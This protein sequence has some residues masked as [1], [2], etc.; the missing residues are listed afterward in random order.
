L[1]LVGYGIE[2]SC[3]IPDWNDSRQ[4][5]NTSLVP[6]PSLGLVYSLVFALVGYGIEES[7]IIPG[8]YDSRQA[9]N[10]SLVPIPSLGLVYSLVFGSGMVLKDHA[11]YQVGITL[12]KPAIPALYQYQ[13]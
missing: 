3:I 7:F 2:G 4:A 6:I 11:S 12:G 5:S 1:A 8:W 13:A 10:T 9:S